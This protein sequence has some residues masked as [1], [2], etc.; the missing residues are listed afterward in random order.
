M[1]IVLHKP[2][3]V[4]STVSDPEGRQTVRDLVRACP[5]HL[6]RSAGSTFTRA[7]CFSSP[8]TATF[9]DGLLHPKRDV[10]KTYVVKVSGRMTRRR[11]RALGAGRR[12]RGRQDAT[13]GSRSSSATRATR[14]G[15]RSHSR[16]AKPADSSHG[17]GHRLSGHAPRARRLRRH[18][19]RGPPS[20]AVARALVTELPSSAKSTAFRER[21]ARSAASA[22][23]PKAGAPHP[24]PHGPRAPQSPEQPRA[25][26]PGTARP[27]APSTTRRSPRPPRPPRPPKTR[28]EGPRAHEGPRQDKGHSQRGRE[29]KQG[30]T[31][32]KRRPASRT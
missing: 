27:R 23:Q 16:G 9:S 6:P 14:P 24:A 7:A 11:P 20:R 28:P 21:A 1:Y 30:E 31:A 12:A 2:R 26:T 4:V 15:S 29:A 8:T 25:V 17:R 10:P 19:R 3:G 13:R 18:H 5:A 22:A 32:E